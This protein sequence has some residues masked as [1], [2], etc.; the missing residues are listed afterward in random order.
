MRLSDRKPP[1]PRLR[2]NDAALLL[3]NTAHGILNT[4]LMRPR[5]LVVEDEPSILDNIIYSLDT[6]GFAPQGCGTAGAA[7]EAMKR[8]TFALVVLDVGL[9]DASGFELCK[10]LRRE[11]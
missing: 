6:D 11:S 8:E 5:I 3:L 1:R 7:R 10:E 4:P 9:P 2:N